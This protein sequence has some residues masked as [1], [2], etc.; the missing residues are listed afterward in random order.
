MEASAISSF[1]EWTVMGLKVFFS[2]R[3]QIAERVLVFLISGRGAL[4]LIAYPL[5]GLILFKKL[6]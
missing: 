2:P 3:I 1:V 6:L 5:Y 4:G